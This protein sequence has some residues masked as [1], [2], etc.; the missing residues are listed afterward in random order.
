MKEKEEATL[1]GSF[2]NR[3]YFRV[4]EIV[5][6]VIFPHFF[7]TSESTFPSAYLYLHTRCRIFCRQK[8][9]RHFYLF[10]VLDIEIF[11]GG[12]TIVKLFENI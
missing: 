1:A 11:L 3:T 7:Y 5:F 9:N 4:T 6:F 2:K 10:L 8:K 12:I